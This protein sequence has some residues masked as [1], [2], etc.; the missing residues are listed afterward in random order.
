[1][2][3]HGAHTWSIRLL[4]QAPVSQNLEDSGGSFLGSQGTLSLGDSFPPAALLTRVNASPS[5]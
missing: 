4:G 5:G 1:M 2:K 3:E